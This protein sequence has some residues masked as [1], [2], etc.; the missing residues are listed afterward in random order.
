[1][2]NVN[3]T[4]AAADGIVVATVRRAT[5]SVTAMSCFSFRS[6]RISVQCF[7]VE[8]QRRFGC[9]E[10]GDE[11]EDHGLLLFLRPCILRTEAP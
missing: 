3:M 5:S 10:G 8:P 4:I 6:F 11:A 9:D 2:L 7:K 1:M